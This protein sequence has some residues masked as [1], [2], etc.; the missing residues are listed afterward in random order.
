MKKISERLKKL[1]M[2]TSGTVF[3]D[4][5]ERRARIRQLH[6]KTY[7]LSPTL[8]QEE[9]EN[10]L[11]ARFPEELGSERIPAIIE[12]NADRSNLHEV[13]LSYNRREAWLIAF[14]RR[15]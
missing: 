3:M 9:Y 1:E 14:K 11:L 8:T 4:Y 5:E 10:D 6:A 13:I 15:K 12:S 7:N 2:I